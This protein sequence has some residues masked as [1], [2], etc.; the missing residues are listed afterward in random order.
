[1]PRY[2]QPGEPP[3]LQVWDE[4]ALRADRWSPP[5]CLRWTGGTRLAAA[6]A[7]EFVSNDGLDGLLIRIGALSRYKSIRYWSGTSQTWQP[8]VA[9]A[10]LLGTFGATDLAPADFV[11]GRAHEYFQV[12]GAARSTY[13]ITVLERGADRIVLASE[14]TCAI[15]LGFVTLFEPGALQWVVFLERSRPGVWRYFQAIRAGQGANALATNVPAAYLNRL[16]ALYR[17]VA[18]LPSARDQLLSR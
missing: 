13:R 14:N 15:R 8:L 10:G 5:A 18:A 4:A 3:A 2:T 16:S 7:G 11:P 12:D 9:D 6:L 17:Y 1:M